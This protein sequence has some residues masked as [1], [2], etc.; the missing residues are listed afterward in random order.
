M[1]DFRHAVDDE[2]DMAENTVLLAT[3]HVDPVRLSCPTT[4]QCCRPD[5]KLVTQSSTQAQKLQQRIE[6]SVK[7][8]SEVER[9][10]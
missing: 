4:T 6:P 8:L 5:K 10:F 9:Y 7:S 3:V 2:N 1:V